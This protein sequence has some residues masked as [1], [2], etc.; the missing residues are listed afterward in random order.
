MSVRG[1]KGGSSAH[2]PSRSPTLDTGDAGPGISGLGSWHGV[3]ASENS[4]RRPAA[5]S[6]RDSSEMCGATACSRAQR[7]PSLAEFHS[8]DTRP[9]EIVTQAPNDRCRQPNTYATLTGKAIAFHF[10]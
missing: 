2:E 1:F 8:P 6:L 10:F 7:A 4:E 9:F 3:K 5:F